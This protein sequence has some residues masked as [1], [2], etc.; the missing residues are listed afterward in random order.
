MIL[1]INMHSVC[2][3]GCK[4]SHTH[5]HSVPI[6]GCT[7]SWPRPGLLA[8]VSDNVKPAS[9][10]ILVHFSVHSPLHTPVHE[11]MESRVQSPAYTMTPNIL[12][13]LLLCLLQFHF[14]Y[15]I[16]LPFLLL[17]LWFVT[18]GTC[19]SYDVSGCSLIEEIPLAMSKNI[20]TTVHL[21]AKLGVI[22]QTVA[23]S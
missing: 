3:G 4:L 5:S 10:P 2:L 11:S 7:I 20:E 23:L 21:Y 18:F 8:T 1:N 15:S 19:T 14:I 17:L 9:V 13:C 22:R 16:S 12:V 6:H